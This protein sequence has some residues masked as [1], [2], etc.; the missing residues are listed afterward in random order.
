MN[1]Y[2][3]LQFGLVV[4]LVVAWLCIGIAMCF[5]VKLPAEIMALFSGVSAII[6]L[7]VDA[8]ALVALTR[9]T[10]GVEEV[11]E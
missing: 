9:K 2:Q 8:K 7:L 6:M 5:G 10:N 4:V 11:S 1:P 3:W